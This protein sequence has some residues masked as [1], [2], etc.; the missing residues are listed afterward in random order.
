MTM[1][2]NIA[3]TLGAFALTGSCSTSGHAAVSAVQRSSHH[4]APSQITRNEAAVR[5]VFDKVLSRGKIDENEQLYAPDFI[6]HGLSG[7][8]DR[9]EDRA[10]TLGWR[11]A[12]PDIKMTVLRLVAD[13]DMVAAHWEGTG[14]NTGAGN[15][16]PAT[17]RKIRAQGVT[18]FQFRDGK[19]AEEWSVFDQ[20]TMLRQLDLLK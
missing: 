10:A 13:C 6:A 17:G 1:Q 20:Y 2:F 11:M 16:L 18:F 3:I 9:A 14:T 12:A 4:C 8:S 19:I 7:D 15:G 5:T